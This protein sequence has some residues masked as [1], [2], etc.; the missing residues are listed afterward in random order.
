VLHI[1]LSECRVFQTKERSPCLIAVELYRPDELNLY[2]TGSRHLS[3]DTNG[4]HSDDFN[5]YNPG[6]RVED[7]DSASSSDDSIRIEDSTVRDQNN[8]LVDQRDKYE[9][10]KFDDE[11]PYQKDIQLRNAIT[12]KFGSNKAEMRS[13]SNKRKTFTGKA[14]FSG[15]LLASN[16]FH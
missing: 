15:G 8:Y 1:A 12:S 10:V 11:N 6:G 5:P 16:N 3:M 13:L 2:S 9:E 14:L 7:S 4:R